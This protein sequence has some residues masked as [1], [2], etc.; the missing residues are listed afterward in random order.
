[1]S[2]PCAAVIIPTLRADQRLIE[3]L[4][5][6]EQQT[7]K[8]FEVWVVDNSGK[9]AA[10]GVLA[11]QHWDL[12]LAFV[13][14]GCNVGFGAAI[15]Q[16]ARQSEAPLIATLNDDTVACPVWMAELLATMDQRPE[17]GMCACSVL[18]LGERRL[19]SA[20]MLIAADGSSRQR[21]H[22]EPAARYER[23]RDALLPSGSAAMY[24][25][26]ALEQI[27]WFDE[28][29]FLYCEDTDVG[30]RAHWA[31]WGCAYAPKAVVEHHYSY[32]AGRASALK[33]YYVERNR[34]FVLLK[35]F[36]VRMLWAAPLVT[37]S[38]YWWHAI[39]LFRGRGAAARYRSDEEGGVWRL[40]WV[41]LRAHW[42]AV[43]NWTG[44]RRKRR[45]IRQTARIGAA[46]FVRLVRR[47]SIPA[48]RV[49]EL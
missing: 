1:M 3:C 44:L 6:L 30:L 36:P 42:A 21:G 39:Y 32:S 31:G 9:R 26:A 37:L 8:D 13:E 34:L 40:A 15:N 22:L 17:V 12:R 23:E 4:R 25:R 29:F 5:S 14:N 41:V 11:G 20:G 7:R 16:A 28:E 18:M 48:R 27:G 49:A 35:N 2:V 19:D 45:Q 24:R 38:R 43:R 46:E 33:A 10:R 47:H